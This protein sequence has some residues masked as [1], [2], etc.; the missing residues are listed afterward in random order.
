M[1]VPFPPRFVPKVGYY[2]SVN[3]ST[4]VPIE[5]KVSKIVKLLAEED[6]K[7]ANGFKKVYKK[8]KNDSDIIN[9]FTALENRS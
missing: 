9:F 2:L 8:M 6:R 7:K 1:S 4:A 5:A 3:Q